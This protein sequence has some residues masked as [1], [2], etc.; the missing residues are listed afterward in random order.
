MQIQPPPVIIVDSSPPHQPQ[1]GYFLNG[2]HVFF[3]LYSRV[4]CTPPNRPS[5]DMTLDR[6]GSDRLDAAKPRTAATASADIAEGDTAK[7]CTAAAT[8]AGV[9][10]ETATV[11]PR[12]TTATI[13]VAAPKQGKQ[14]QQAQVSSEPGLGV[15]V[16][17]G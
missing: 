6:V 5:A 13:D 10:M 8:I 14:N 12:T 4:F 16:K 3:P 17:G 15:S 11:K 9:T 7:P 2:I 1:Q